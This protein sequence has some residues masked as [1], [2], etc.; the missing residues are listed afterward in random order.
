MKRGITPDHSPCAAIDPGAD[1]ACGC[2]AGD[3]GG[4]PLAIANRPGLT[5]LTYRVGTYSSFL[6]TML[7]RL[8]SVQLDDGAESPRPLAGLG[9]RT[10]DDPSIALLDA[11]AVVSDVL[12]FYQERIANE[13]YL[14]TALEHR[15]VLELARLVGYRPRPGVA[16][17]VYLALA[18]EQDAR[19]EIPAGTR[20]QSVP[21]QAGESAQSFETVEAL[22]G[23]WEWNAIRARQVRPHWFARGPEERPDELY[24]AGTSTNLRANDP[25]V[26]AELDPGSQ[27]YRVQL[28][29]PELEAGRTRVVLAPW[30]AAGKPPDGDEPG[31][32]PGKSVAAIA[33]HVRGLVGKFS[34]L[35]GFDINV[36]KVAG[37]V[38]QRLGELDHSMIRFVERVERDPEILLWE[39]RESLAAVTEDQTDARS[40]GFT[41]LQPWL[42]AI[43]AE[44]EKVIA[45]LEARIGKLADGEPA[46]LGRV[47]RALSKPPSV[48]PGSS[49][50][51]RRDIRRT[52]ATAST[53]GLELARALNP[54]VA[55]TLADAWAT[56]PVA[57][58]VEIAVV[59]APR[60]KAAPFGA[61]A[62]PETILH[63]NGAPLGQ[64]EWSLGPELEFS[65]SLDEIQ[66]QAA[67]R[68][69]LRRHGQSFQVQFPLAVTE[70][71]MTL[72]TVTVRTRLE[73]SGGEF[74]QPRDVV[75]RMSLPDGRQNEL[76][77]RATESGVEV[78]L[79][80]GLPVVAFGQQPGR[81]LV[82]QLRLD[83]ALVHDRFERRNV[84]VVLNGP[85]SVPV[86]ERRVLALDAVYDGIVPGS[87]VVVDRPAQNTDQPR[88][89][90]LTRVQDVNSVGRTGYGLTSKVTVLE[91]ED[92]WLFDDDI[93]LEVARR[94]TV[95]AAPAELALADEPIDPVLEPVD[96]DEIEL[97]G[98]Y[99]GL[100]VGR[101]IIVS[102]ERLIEQQDRSLR[103][104]EGVRAAEL[105]M[106][107]SVEHRPGRA[108]TEGGEPLPGDRNHTVIRLAAP[109]AYTYRRDTAVIHGNV[110]AATHGE[111]RNEVLGSGDGSQAHQRFTLSFQPLTFV[112]AATPAGAASTLEVRVDGVRWREVDHAAA[113]GPDDRAYVTRTEE[114]GRTTVRFGDGRHGAR[115]STGTDNIA[116]TYRQGIGRAGNVA[117]EQ[118]SQLATRPLGLKGVINPLPAT[119]GVD[120]DRRDD[121]RRNAPLAV[122]ALDR[123][124]SVKD[125]ADFARTFAGIAKA[126]AARLSDGERQLVHLTVAAAGDAPLDPGSSL[127]GRLEQALRLHGDPQQAL[128]VAVREPR[129]LIIKAGVQVAADHRWQ[130]VAPRIR[131][132]LL[133]ALGF[134]RRSLGQDVT[135]S[136]V[137]ALIQGVRG[138]DWLDLDVLDTVGNDDVQS[139]L[140]GLVERLLGGEKGKQPRQRLRAELGRPGPDGL[141][142]AQL[143]YLH[144]DLPETLILEER[145]A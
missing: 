108:P 77:I 132:T 82:G 3:Q 81:A 106:I 68:L 117:A 40:R 107:A 99:D 105:A 138:V 12:T 129:F 8:S 80:G 21:A 2:G 119:G 55:D 33:E 48:S 52:F 142:P 72:G 58:P 67:V 96:S 144:P 27:L 24:L 11:A 89:L 23:R 39:L 136:E 73:T 83:V 101:R 91:L 60:V 32:R 71:T 41:R 78:N 45:P 43:V 97:D 50:D 92:A 14:R 127:L 53:F 109:L 88:A 51:L 57:P 18:L 126:S 103:G 141:L 10:A 90:I 44:L 7:D 31:T 104:V 98:L 1:S 26:L 16:A 134:D 79:N 46:L 85:D 17:S 111:T 69:R 86:P 6:A 140:A 25:I 38:L 22:P 125:Y 84:H 42:D 120:P 15:S 59:R 123:L 64:R 66:Q 122:T 65:V 75:M 110:A 70:S 56:V 139:G 112:A 5:A 36:G 130:D 61:G 35:S 28:A 94:T 137:I 93:L 113:L 102:G 9:V 87:L 115:V 54:A 128:Q 29:E 116:A 100:E 20:A 4:T 34:D 95:Y 49:A 74:P 145:T 19:V 133:D 124:V 30:I 76:R 13:G 121:I 37:R 135:A 131:A 47:V 114:D 118:I 63:V 62:P 143:I